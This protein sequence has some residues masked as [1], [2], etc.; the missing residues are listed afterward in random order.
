[1]SRDPAQPEV[2]SV[3]RKYGRPD[4][5]RLNNLHAVSVGGASIGKVHVD[6]KSLFK[7]SRW[8]TLDGRQGGIIY[9]DFSIRQP[10]DVRLSS[11]IVEVTLDDEDDYLKRLF[12]G[13]GAMS[14][15]QIRQYGPRQIRGSPT[16][17]G[18]ITRHKFTPE[19]E[20]GSIAG[21]GGLGRESVKI[22]ESSSSWK[23]EGQL[24]T[25]GK[26]RACNV[27]Q[28][29][30]TEDELQ[31]PQLQGRVFHTAFSFEHGGQPFYVRVN[32]RGKLESKTSNLRHKISSR[33][34]GSRSFP[35]A[36]TLI[37]FG[38][39][40]I[41]T[42]PL[43]ELEKQL[44]LEMEIQNINVPPVVFPEVQGQTAFEGQPSQPM[45][46]PSMILPTEEPQFNPDNASAQKISFRPKPS[47]GCE[48]E[49]VMLSRTPSLH[50]DF[51]VVLSDSDPSSVPFSKQLYSHGLSQSDPELTTEFT[52][53]TREGSA[54][55][56]Q[57]RP[58]KQPETFPA[59]T[60]YSDSRFS[61]S[62]GNYIT[63]L[64]EDLFEKIG[65]R[66][67][68][69]L[70]RV[71]ESL[72]SL[73]KGFALQ[74]GYKAET[75][76]HQ[77][78]SVFIH[79]YSK[80]IAESFKDQFILEDS[81]PSEAER[82]EQYNSRIDR[83]LKDEAHE[84][85][86]PE[87]LS[88]IDLEFRSHG[89]EPEQGGDDPPVPE[90]EN[91]PPSVQEQQYRTLM[92]GSS[93][94]LWLI[95]TMQRDASLS[96]VENGLMEQ[97]GAKILKALPSPHLSRKAPLKA[98]T[99]TF[100]LDWDPICFL[101]EQG[102]SQPPW[103]AFE[104]A[105]TLTGSLDDAQAL[106]T[107]DYVSQVWPT[108]GE[109]A[110]ALITEA[111][112]NKSGYSA[113]LD[114]PDGGRLTA[115]IGSG[116]VVVTVTG[117][118]P[119]IVEVG[120]QL[121]WLGAALR[122]S[123]VE[124]GVAI[125]SPSIHVTGQD[126]ASRG[127]TTAEIFCTVSFET[128][129]PFTTSDELQGHCWQKMFRNPVIV[130][131]YP[132]SLKRHSGLGLE[133][134]LAMMA[135]LVGSTQISDFDGR[136]F[137]KGFSTMLVAMK[138]AE[139]LIVW[140]YFYNSLQG[141]QSYLYDCRDDTTDTGAQGIG[142]VELDTARHVVGASDAAYDKIGKT[143][144]PRPHDGCF[145]EKVS[146][147]GGKFITIG[148]TI[149]PGVKDIP[150]HVT[151]NGY[152]SKLRW[153]HD[154]Y[155]ILWDEVDKRGWLVNGTSA[156]LHLVRTSL[157]RSSVDD[158]F[159]SALRFSPDKMVYPDK[160]G[161]PSTATKVLLHD[162]NRQL[163]IWAGKFVHTT[164]ITSTKNDDGIANEKKVLKKTMQ[165][166]LFEDIVED[167]FSFLERMIAYQQ[168]GGQNGINLKLRVR[169]HLE[170]WQFMDTATSSILHGYVATLDPAAYH[171][172]EFARS[173]SAV[174]L[175]GKGFG[176]I[177][178]PIKV[179]PL[180][181]TLPKDKYYLAASV[182]DLKIIQEREQVSAPAMAPNFEWLTP[183]SPVAPCESCAYGRSPSNH[184]L[185]Q[186]L[187]PQALDDRL[188][189][190]HFSRPRE[191]EDGGAVIFGDRLRRGPSFNNRPRED[192]EEGHA[193]ST[194][195]SSAA[196]DFSSAASS[197]SRNQESELSSFGRDSQGQ[198]SETE[199]TSISAASSSL[200]PLASAYS[201]EEPRQ[202]INK[203]K[204]IA[205]EA[206][207]STNDL[208][209]RQTAHSLATQDPTR[210][211]VPDRGMRVNLNRWMER[212][213]NVKGNLKR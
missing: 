64:A 161:K 206:D 49:S 3:N 99:A 124:T 34:F 163:E 53:Y 91:D 167:R 108:S 198:G 22:V 125:C 16:H 63:T 98:H 92:T 181:R 43:D 111:I 147:S 211:V 40:E 105:I 67:E 93:A 171:W 54:A 103:E 150:I 202:N 116:K 79:K 106:T 137:I 158:V 28:W 4:F 182:S 188:S 82:V 45:Q 176:E 10:S 127:Q 73:L 151:L 26:S 37:N 123:S 166:T 19:I 47:D 133:M 38:T 153:L 94:Y 42:T 143:R 101:K 17:K 59:F 15:L 203:G 131:G 173:I 23:L 118:T 107:A 104:K 81:G 27:L 193:G 95:K 136:A 112:R 50:E 197:E 168:K 149:A 142:L 135:T 204:Q 145:L 122:S 71:S 119:I 115:R 169:T 52:E 196:Q 102:Y 80:R 213:R 60:T 89:K 148:A 20:I 36:V 87:A 141:Y 51:Q 69:I 1:M 129:L 134:P 192:I 48:A 170:G 74:M 44:G 41:F 12:P 199:A 194:S 205:S 68:Q 201:T 86:A 97:I 70:T 179:C 114:L 8:G 139:D 132:I 175:F 165:A 100:E 157:Q 85:F 190:K 183:S 185:V 113:S 9:L 31:T 76:V 164:E 120:Q 178:E 75:T 117:V 72:P 144:L 152:V 130:E 11:A 39:P 155:V 184:H 30:F 172:V 209:S 57:L 88:E 110:I 56:D 78:V 65:S 210:P 191:L 160:V 154:Q 66:D 35:E 207:D 6:C 90:D 109:H 186:I 13:D 138:V 140:H 58:P 24:L 62:H 33:K 14:P 162:I 126:G 7:K 46:E 156:L 5:Q 174:I 77:E 55:A 2:F 187:C 61:N 121:A 29:R 96:R 25:N 212:L 18:V 146:I 189:P 195:V 21:V 84:P 83:F 180:W 159:S 177:I 200:A 128:K 32:V 208:A